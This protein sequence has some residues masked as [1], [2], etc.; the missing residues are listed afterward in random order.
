MNTTLT[1]SSI[2]LSI[3][4]NKNNPTHHLYNNN[5]TWWCHLTLHSGPYKE[6]IRKSLRTKNLNEAIIKRDQLFEKLAA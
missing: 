2:T 6:R 4:I 5:G 3:R 1:Q